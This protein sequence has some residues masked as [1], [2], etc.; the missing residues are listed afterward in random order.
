[1]NKLLIWPPIW[2]AAA[3][4]HPFMMDDYKQAIVSAIMILLGGY[5]MWFMCKLYEKEQ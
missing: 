2:A 4:I 1:M 5:G 3:A